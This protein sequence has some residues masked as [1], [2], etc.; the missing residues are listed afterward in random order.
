MNEAHSLVGWE[1]FPF[2]LNSSL[3]PLIPISNLTSCGYTP[4][5]KQIIT[6]NRKPII[7]IVI[8]NDVEIKVE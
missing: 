2:V 7:A 8:L 5:M 3:K 4:F 1:P 6:N